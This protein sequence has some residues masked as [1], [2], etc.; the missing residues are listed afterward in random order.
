[1]ELLAILI[2]V[3]FGLLV[4]RFLKGVIGGILGH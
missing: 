4:Y 2:I 1:M 3:G